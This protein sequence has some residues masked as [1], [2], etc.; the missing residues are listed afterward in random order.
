MKRILYLCSPVIF[1]IFLNLRLQAQYCG[2]SGPS[3]CTPASNAVNV[4]FY[5]PDT[6]LP[7]ATDGVPYNQ[8][9]TFVTPGT[10]D[11]YTLNDVAV[12]EIDNL[13]CSL[14]WAS[15][16]SNNQIAGGGSG[17]IRITGTTLDAPGEYEILVYA[18]ATVSNVPVIGT[19]TVGPL[20]IDSL[21]GLGYYTRVQAPGGIC[22]PVNT[23]SKGLTQSAHG[24]ITTPTISGNSVVCVGGTT[25]LSISG[26]NY[27]AYVWSTGDVSPTINAN[28]AGTY[29]VTVYDNCNSATA[30]KTL[31]SVPAPTASVTP[32]N[33]TVCP[34]SL[35]TLTASGGGS[36][37]W[38]VGSTTSSIN[39]TPSATKTYTV[40]VTAANSCTAAASTTLSVGSAANASISPASVSVCGGQDTTLTASGGSTYL[41]NTGATTSSIAVAPSTTTIY[42]V[43]VSSG[44]CSATASRTVDVTS[45]EPVITAN[46]PTSLC[47][48]GS[49]TLQVNAGFTSYLWN[50]GD[51]TQA[52]TVTQTGS[53]SC[54]VTSSSGC[55][56][57]TKVVNVSISNGG[58]TP[59]VTASNSF[60]L[61]PGG[62]TTL[63]AGI[64]Y[65]T[66]SWSVGVG[67]E[68][69][70]VSNTDTGTYN[71]TVTVTQGACSGSAAVSVNISNTPVSVSFSPPG[72]IFACAGSPVA[73]DAGAGY[74]SYIWSNNTSAETIQPFSSGSYY[75]TVTQ[76]NGCTGSAGV[77]VTITTVPPV[78]ITPADSQNICFGQS[79]T[80]T[81]NGNYDTYAWNTGDSTPVIEV[82][83][84]GSYS[85][86]VSN[87]GCQAFSDTVSVN[88][89]PA[90]FP[91]ISPNGQQNVCSGQNIILSADTSYSSYL[92]SNGATSQSVAIDSAGTYNLSVTQNGC[93]GSAVIPA[94]V[95]INPSPAATIVA[96]DIETDYVVLQAGPEGANFQWLILQQTGDSA[97]ANTLPNDTVVCDNSIGNY[98]VIASLNGC[99]DSS[100]AIAAQ[101]SGQSS[102]IGTISGLSD[103]VIE[104]NPAGDI[105]NVIYNLYENKNM[106]ILVLDMTGRVVLSAGNEM[107]DKGNHKIQIDV[108]A[109]PA[110]IYL[111]RMSAATDG[112]NARF[113]KQ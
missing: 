6:S 99:S 17:C 77:N 95:T 110:G 10:V 30:S 13:P 71:Y 78:T 83:N 21:L 47:S 61:C 81:A 12:A 56:G 2:N 103:F 64:G 85:L 74:N 93:S 86:V 96:A 106:Q 36:Y 92:W 84:S 59:V 40:T 41:W 39:V 91:A 102:G 58:L 79:V 100:A 111:L 73:I 23:T 1:L 33:E 72:P 109:L 48:G 25:T 113:V 45:L 15:N 87:N 31:T 54:M 42:D 98:L 76:S 60:N 4:G 24:A 35:V 53:Y 80:L 90:V 16:Q 104:P 112:L 22:A 88:V 43:T 57:T 101:C 26:G 37:R 108:H 9:I 38:S 5:P 68:T 44:S 97:L 63:D 75:V 52:I 50:T 8:V 65:D 11:G 32:G 14:C 28:A 107:Q 51:T 82:N 69:I 3:I 67:S 55:S 20:N 18:S 49:V 34:G 29:T 27:Y 62:V 19:I 7:C 66:Y 46:G 105:L 70:E 94:T 89:L